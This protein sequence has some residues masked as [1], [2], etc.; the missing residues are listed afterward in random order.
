MKDTLLAHVRD[1][2]RPRLTD[3]PVILALSGGP[4]STCLLALLLKYQKLYPL[5]LHVAHVDHGWRPE[6]AAEATALCASCPV[7]FHL[8]T[9]DMDPTASNLEDLGRQERLLY[10][11]HLYQELNAEALLMAH[12]A[13]DQ[14]ETVLKRL[15]EGGPLHG[16]LPEKMLHGMRIL[17]PL[18]DIRKER[19]LAYLSAANIPYLTDSTNT[20][21]RFLRSRMR[22]TLI[23]LLEAH[24]GKKITGP[25]CRLAKRFQS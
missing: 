18:L 14:A 4:D 22:Q 13:D 20:D 7:P 25:L 15:F 10:F 24:F 12:Q 6:S 19:L 3:R 17:R 21:P 2:L 16:L 8:H 23:P 5:T 1:F 11:S 9:L